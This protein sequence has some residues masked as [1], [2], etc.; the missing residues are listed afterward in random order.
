MGRGLR[1]SVF[2]SGLDVGGVQRTTLTLADALA[3]RGHDV[4]LVVPSARGPFRSLVSPRVRLVD[5]ENTLLRLPGVRS[6]KRHRALLSP[7]FL[8]SYLRRTRPDAL[9]SA[10]H[11]VNVAALVA[12]RLAG[13]RTPLVIGQRTHLSRAIRHT[14][15]PGLR[16]PLLG[17]LVRRTYP[18]AEAAVAVCDGVA[19]D[20]AEVARLPRA[21]VH[22]I[23]NPVVT[24]EVERLAAA[25]LDHP[26]FRPGAPPVVVAVG[27]LV[28]QKDFPT[29]LRGFARLLGRR[30]ARLVIVGEGRLRGALEARIRREGLGGRVALPGYDPNPFRWMARA[31]VCALSSRY[32][33]LPGV[34]IQAL[35][36]GAPVVSTDCPSGPGEILD[37]GRYGALVPVGDADALGEALAK[38]LAAPPPRR[39][40]VRGAARFTAEACARRYESLLLG[41]VG[42]A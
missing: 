29:L 6:T 26:W 14:R 31:S 18:W 41:L 1:L 34:L 8:A 17:T 32:E 12:R 24:P 15:V 36:C 20:L 28:P 11:Y 40:Q 37:G 39:H 13:T 9:L 3:A 19:D 21:S 7:P 42:G 22:T 4:E 30:D 5:L 16:R 23:Y 27:R 10:S 38:Q 2:L 33:G 35:A 25:P